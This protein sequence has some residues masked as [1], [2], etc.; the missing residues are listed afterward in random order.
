MRCD[1][2]MP[3]WTRRASAVAVLCLLSSLAMAQETPTLPVVSV[4][5]KAEPE[6][7]A[8]PSTQQIRAQDLERNFVNDWRKLGNVD[9]GVDWSEGS[10]TLV[11]RGLDQNRLLMTVDGIRMPDY[12]RS[13]RTNTSGYDMVDFGTL[14]SLDV[15]RSNT[16]SDRAAIGSEVGLRTLDPEDLLTDSR[17]FGFLG[18][19]DYQGSDR[20]WGL[21]AAVASR[22]GAPDV[23]TSVLLQ[24][25][26]RKGHEVKNQG[27]N[28]VY[29]NQRTKPDPRDTDKISGLFKLQQQIGASHRIGLT[30]EYLRNRYD[31]DSLT[32]ASAAT[33]RRH[34]N[35]DEQK[36]QRVSLQYDYSGDNGASLL[37]DAQAIVW[38]QKME[39][40][41][42]YDDYRR[43]TGVHYNWRDES[44]E[45]TMYGAQ[46]HVG[47]ILAGDVFSHSL[48]LGGE[49]WH[50]KVTQYT[51]NSPASG[52][53]AAFLHYN[54]RDMPVTKSDAYGL[55]IQDRI[56]WSDER[57]AFTG[58]LR[59]DHYEY[60]PSS[61]MAY[62]KNPAHPAVQLGNSS[63][64]QLSPKMM[65]EWRVASKATLYAQ[66]S[67]GFRAPTTQELYLSYGGPGTYVQIG[68]PDLKPERSRS[69]ELGAQL[70]DDDLGGKV[71]VFHNR[72]RNFID[73][74]NRADP[75]YPVAGI[76]EFFNRSRV[77]IYGA[78]VAGHWRITPQWTVS[79]AMAWADGKDRDTGSRINSVAP[80]KVLLGLGYA[81]SEWGADA[82]ARISSRHNQTASSS[83]FKTPGY[84]VMD[85][86]AWWQ[87]AAVKG[88]RVQAGVENVFDRKYWLYAD[89]PSSASLGVIDRYTQPGRT[90]NVMLTWQ[91]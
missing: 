32:Y 50:G 84:G 90:F 11:I 1:C 80:V 9:P 12:Y 14:S 2:S 66:Y 36:R 61:D 26:G 91:Y 71:S 57:F 83:D 68:N 63:G 6:K 39:Q 22:F 29:G 79:G 69:Y 74:D 41:Y 15:V 49:W 67:H 77:R 44:Y 54:Q 87:P 24:V 55:F 59:Y 38:W 75:A 23:A 46:G 58:A 65:F 73:S 64:S 18:R 52:P 88:L 78:E 21:N 62:Q 70:G 35:D 25:G 13:N 30:A 34:I 43:K 4:I 47:K 3:S 82:R 42:H 89:V 53:A 48:R 19:A 27:D 28:G 33:T 31:G 72:Y 10:K 17:A 85:L 16:G 7:V 81:R 8:P 60:K 56:S 76:M 20:S 40:S 5:G 51:G 86:S 45:Q 37:D